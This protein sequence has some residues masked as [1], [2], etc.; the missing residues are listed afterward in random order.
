MGAV[1]NILMMMCANLV[2]FALGLEGLK[3]LV[4]G[5]T[6]TWLGIGFLLAA[7]GA[8]FTGAQFMFE[9]REAEKRKGISMKC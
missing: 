2:G 6:G 8:L 4:L 7:C 5:I 9:V 3:G 1:F